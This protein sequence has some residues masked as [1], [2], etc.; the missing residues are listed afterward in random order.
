MTPAAGIPEGLTSWR[1]QEPPDEIPVP[2][3]SPETRPWIL[4]GFELEAL[5][6]ETDVP[7]IGEQ[8]LAVC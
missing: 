4:E 3:I 5:Y 6:G 2:S 1:R 8:P 7:S